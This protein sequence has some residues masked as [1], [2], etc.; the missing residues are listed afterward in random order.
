MKILIIEDE[1]HAVIKL[2]QL[3]NTI[4]EHIIIIGTLETIEESVLWFKKNEAPDLILMDIQLSDG[5]CFEIFSQTE[6]KTPVVFTTAY[7]EYAIRAFKVN[8][9]NYLLKP[10][11]LSALASAIQKYRSI[12]ST[13]SADN[14]KIKNLYKDITVNYRSRFLVKAGLQYNSIPAEEIKC[15]YIKERS[16]F[17]IT[18]NGKNYDLDYS[19]EQIQTMVSPESFFR[20]NRHYIVNIKSIASIFSYSTNRLKLKLTN[21]T[22]NDD[23][24]VSRDKV[25]E[26]KQ[27]LNK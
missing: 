5:I 3:L 15:F 9:I 27:W 1:K 2:K 25:T 12:Y 17:L 4:D 16:T 19:L 21:E 23:L 6:I 8:S 18:M 26:F 24:V 11:D 7:D 22:N 10:I 20:I 13:N 14:N